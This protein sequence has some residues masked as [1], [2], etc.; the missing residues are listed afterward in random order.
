MLSHT[1]RSQSKPKI[2]V[3]SGTAA[4]QNTKPVTKDEPK[5]G[6]GFIAL[7]LFKRSHDTRHDDTLYN[8]IQHY[9][10]WYNDTQHYD[11]WYNDTQHDGLN[12][13]TQFNVTLCAV[14]AVRRFLS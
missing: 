12:C 3:I 7:L 14:D 5:T 1:G 13:D 10:H 4:I 8:D 6:R 11:H 2:L 9:D